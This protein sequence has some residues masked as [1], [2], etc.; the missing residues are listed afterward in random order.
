MRTC[1]DQRQGYRE[2]AEE[3]AHRLQ[4]GG[5]Y[6][7]PIL[8]LPELPTLSKWKISHKTTD[9]QLLWIVRSTSNTRQTVP[10]D[11]G[12]LE[13][14]AGGP[15]QRHRTPSSPA[16]LCPAAVRSARAGH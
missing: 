15:A 3:R 6:F 11:N 16:G 10:R 7:P 14:S 1:F 5:K 2:V 4:T 12:F 8:V 9:V 13:R